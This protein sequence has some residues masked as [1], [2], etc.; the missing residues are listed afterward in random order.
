M[1]YKLMQDGHNQD[2]GIFMN[3]TINKQATIR[4]TRNNWSMLFAQGV[5]SVCNLINERNEL[6]PIDSEYVELDNAIKEHIDSYLLIL[7][8]AVDLEEW[9]ELKEAWFNLKQKAGHFP[10]DSMTDLAKQIVKLHDC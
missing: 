7:Y 10:D 1:N 3:N 4:M 9:P 8:H 5:N 2:C 6:L